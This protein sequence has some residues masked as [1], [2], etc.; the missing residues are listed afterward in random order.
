MEKTEK[1]TCVLPRWEHTSLSLDSREGGELFNRIGKRGWE[2]VSVHE[3]MAY[4]KRPLPVPAVK[5]QE[6]MER[7][8]SERMGVS[9]FS[10]HEAAMSAVPCSCGHESCEGWQLAIHGRPLRLSDVHASDI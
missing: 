10:F 2:L 6:E 3:N 1:S 5:T 9:F 4:F 8:W 7:E